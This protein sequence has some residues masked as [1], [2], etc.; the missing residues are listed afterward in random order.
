MSESLHPLY[1][2]A[3]TEGE[4]F[5]GNRLE[6]RPHSDFPNSEHR[7]EA[8]YRG[9]RI[10]IIDI[11]NAPDRTPTLAGS[12]VEAPSIKN[13]GFSIKHLV[14]GPIKIILTRLGRQPQKS[15]L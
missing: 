1:L 11:D 10:T 5:Y 4:L 12:E 15:Q 2:E 8:E 6:T 3:E 13:G 7:R 9:R 14:E